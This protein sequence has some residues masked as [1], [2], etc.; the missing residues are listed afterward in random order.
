MKSQKWITFSSCLIL[1]ACVATPIK[2]KLSDRLSL[3]NLGMSK[4]EVQTIFPEAYPGGQNIKE[5]GTVVEGLELKDSQYDI[6]VDNF[7]TQLLHFYFIDNKL[8]R[9]GSPQDWKEREPDT[10]IEDRRSQ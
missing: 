3:I 7:V 2:E 1:A 6:T 8:V 10:I 5:D 4:T 9:W